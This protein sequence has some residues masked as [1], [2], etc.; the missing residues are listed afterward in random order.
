MSCGCETSPLHIYPQAVRSAGLLQY[1]AVSMYE[2]VPNERY[3]EIDEMQYLG[4]ATHRT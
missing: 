4:N 2:G 1:V 3:V